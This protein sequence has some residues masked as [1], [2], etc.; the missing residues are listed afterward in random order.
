MS[1]AAKDRW[2]GWRGFAKSAAAARRRPSERSVGCDTGGLRTDVEDVTGG[3]HHEARRR[4]LGGRDLLLSGEEAVDVARRQRV[5]GRDAQALA[6]LCRL[7]DARRDDDREVGLLLLEG[8]RA[9]QSAEDRHVAEPRQLL[10][11]SLVTL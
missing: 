6:G 1:P 11:G 4:R 2:C 7:H 5:L 10:L 3:R 9:E 8:G